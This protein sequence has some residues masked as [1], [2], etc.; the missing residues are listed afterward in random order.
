M[1][2]PREAPQEVHDHWASIPNCAEIYLLFQPFGFG[3]AIRVKCQGW[4]QL[5]NDQAATGQAI[6]HIKNK[7]AMWWAKYAGWEEIG[8]LR[9]GDAPADFQGQYRA[10][11]KRLGY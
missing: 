2:I 4:G 8:G 6:Y 3:P 5:A 7:R 1:A 9:R 11:W 10:H